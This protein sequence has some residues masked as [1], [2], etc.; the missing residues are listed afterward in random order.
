MK[1]EPIVKIKFGSVQI[2]PYNRFGAIAKYTCYEG[3]ELHGK[4][5]RV[6]VCQGDGK[7]SLQPPE[8]RFRN[9]QSLQGKYCQLRGW[10]FQINQF[11][12]Y[13]V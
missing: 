1:C 5:A 6:R 12:P 8:C 7:W 9:N 13:K 11:C 4:Q 10:R 2:I 3:Y